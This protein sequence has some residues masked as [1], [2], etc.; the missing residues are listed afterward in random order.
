MLETIGLAL[1]GRAG[2]RLARKLGLS[3]SRDTLL[4]LV[5]ALPDPDVDTVTVLGVDDFAL[6]RVYGTL[7][8]SIRTGRPVD[9]L[10][11]RTAEPVAEWLRAHPGA[12]VICRD[13]AST[14]T[15]FTGRRQS[16]SI[17]HFRCTN[18]F[19]LPCPTGT[20][21]AVRP[22]TDGDAVNPGETMPQIIEPPEPAQAHT[23]DTGIVPAVRNGSFSVPEDWLGSV[24]DRAMALFPRPIVVCDPPFV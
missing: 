15:F 11:E 18:S 21:K 24:L 13:R 5:K 3:A 9:V 14:S 8:I 23:P 7:L 2:A 20:V 16:S 6:R 19:L 4:R 12:E 1:A 17:E 10:P 22:P